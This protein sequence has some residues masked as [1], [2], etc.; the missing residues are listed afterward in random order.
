LPSKAIDNA[1]EQRIDP[2]DA[3]V[4]RAKLNWYYYL[5]R[6][7]LVINKGQMINDNLPK[8]SQ[9]IENCYTPIRVVQRNEV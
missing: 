6:L 7:S 4:V 8:F 1:I 5:R 3:D 2:S 9:T